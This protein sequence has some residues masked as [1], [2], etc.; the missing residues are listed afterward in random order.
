MKF[1]MASYGSRGDIEPCVAASRELLRRGHEVQ[2]AVPPDQVGLAEAV[3]LSAVPYGLEFGP[4]MD[5]HRDFWTRFFRDAWKSRDVAKLWR[6][7]WEPTA[8]CWDD[9]ST[10]LLS[11]ADGADLL[12]TSLTFEE[13]AANVAEYYDIPLATLHHFPARAHGQLFTRPPA[14]LTRSAMKGYEWLAW[15]ISRN[16]EDAQRRELGLS[17]ATRPAQWRITDRGSLEIQAYDELCFSGLAAEWGKWRDQRP[18]VGALTMELPTEA[19]DEVASWIAAGPPP[20][21]F[22][23]GSIAVESPG[24]TLSIIAAACEQ[25]GQRALVGAGW[26]DFSDVPDSEHVKVV[27]AVN[28]AAVFGACRAIV[29]H[30]GA[31]TL[32]AGLRAGVPQLILWTWPDQS[33]RG[34][35]AKRL[36]VGAVRRLSSTTEGSLVSDLR[37][38]LAPQYAARARDIAPRMTKPEESIAATADLLEKFASL[39]RVG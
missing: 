21:Y 20:I 19:D 9:I 3:G 14:S 5:V 37:T 27:S 6:E 16:I 35:A 29:H 15:R 2:L 17:K 32:A 39:R 8:Q 31:G 11:L 30:G 4:W 34:V 10:T 28:F 23:F 24:E 36:G 38:I 33:L 25:L 1:V 12:F 22:G 7:V 13:A 26:S 18:F